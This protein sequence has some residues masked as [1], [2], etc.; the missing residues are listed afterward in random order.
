M[1]GVSLQTANRFQ[2]LVARAQSAWMKS[3]KEAAVPNQ[4]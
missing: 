2:I 1:H 3:Q 4:R